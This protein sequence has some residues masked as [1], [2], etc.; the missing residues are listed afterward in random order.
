MSE[1][2][3]STF[4]IAADHPSLPGHFPGSPVVPGVVVLDFVLQA[5]AAWRQSP[6]HATGL[7]QVKFHAP[8]LPGECADV[9]LELASETLAFRVSHG[10]RLIA[11]GTFTL[12]RA[13]AP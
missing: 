3:H 12:A 1:Q 9:S 5:A 11:Q 13:A 2:H 7:R 6:V 8:L 4:T 10:E